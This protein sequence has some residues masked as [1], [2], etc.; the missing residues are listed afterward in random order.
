MV[1]QDQPHENLSVRMFYPMETFFNGTLALA[2]RDQETNV[3][4]WWA[5]NARLTNLSG[6]LLGAH[7]A[8]AGLIVFWVGA[9]NLFEVAHFVPEKPIYEQGLILLPHLA[10]LRWWAGL[11]G[12]VLD[13]F[14]Y[15]LSRVI[16][17][18]SSALLGFVVFIMNLWD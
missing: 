8:N 9:V 3:F 10:T 11:E 13:T 14:P 2:S 1:A 5:R 6:K 12:E 4:A 16:H 18:I 17:L 15:F 7:V